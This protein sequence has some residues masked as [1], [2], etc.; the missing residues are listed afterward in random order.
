MERIYFDSVAF[1]YYVEQ[2]APWYTRIDARLA[3]GRCKSW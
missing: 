2:R 3:A 1:I